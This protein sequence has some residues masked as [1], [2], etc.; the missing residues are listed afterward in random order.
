MA[1]LPL[2]ATLAFSQT[3]NATA[4]PLGFLYDLPKGWKVVK[5]SGTWQVLTREGQ[6][7]NEL[8]LVGGSVSLQAKT[9]WDDELQKEDEQM[10]KK[11]GPWNKSGGVQSFNAKSGT[12]M[13]MLFKG[14]NQGVKFE[15]QVWTLLAN[16]K[17]FGIFAIYPEDKH[18]TIYAD[19]YHLAGTL[20]LDPSLKITADSELA[21]KFVK[22]LAGNRWVR[23]T[24]G[25]SGSQNGLGGT[26]VDRS[27]TFFNDGTFY[28]STRSMAFVSAGEFSSTSTSSD[29][30]TG[31]WKILTEGNKAMLVIQ[32]NGTTAEETV[33]IR[34]AGE[35]ILIGKDAYKKG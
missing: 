22:V 30:V 10:M 4:N 32:P 24:S 26:S 29:D 2:I 27:L 12:G 20:R 9:S 28:I 34:Q 11:L 35:F 31:K 21:K 17:R 15:S 18:K 19:L 23:T 7:E 6:T 3:A 14:E 33:E 13:L 25:N 16:K 8:Y 1:L 5:T